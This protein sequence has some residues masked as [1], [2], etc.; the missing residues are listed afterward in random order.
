M[1]DPVW[2]TRAIVDAI[3]RE[4]IEEHGGL[5]GIRDEGA[6]ESAL[7]RPQH[8]W[9]YEESGLCL[10]AASYGFGLAKNHAYVDGNK[11]TAFMAIYVFLELNGLELDAPESEAVEAMEAVVTGRWDEPDLAEWIERHTRPISVQS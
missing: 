3:H 2:L 11:R 9:V 8:K 1:N 10:L 5:T 6:L 7:A 4:M